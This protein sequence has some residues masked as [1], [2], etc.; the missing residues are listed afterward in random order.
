MFCSVQRDPS[1]VW[2]LVRFHVSHWNSVFFLG[3]G[4]III[5]QQ[6]GPHSLRPR[7]QSRKRSQKQRETKSVT[8]APKESTSMS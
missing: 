7:Q 1:E 3:K 5:Q 2:S 4:N 6:G 8:K